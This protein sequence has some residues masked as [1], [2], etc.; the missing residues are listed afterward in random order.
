[1]AD[2]SL[3]IFQLRPPALEEVGLVAALKSRLDRAGSSQ[4]CDQACQ[5]GEG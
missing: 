4:Q 3:L 5:P 1:M 2:M